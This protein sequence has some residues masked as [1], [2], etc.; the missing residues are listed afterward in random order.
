MSSPT[1]LGV[2]A[3]AV[4]IAVVRPATVR[5]QAGCPAPLYAVDAGGRVTQG[6]KKALVDAASRGDPLRVG[7]RI[8]YG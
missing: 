5:A 6:S 1:A 8:A 2:I 3:T 4:A 7:W